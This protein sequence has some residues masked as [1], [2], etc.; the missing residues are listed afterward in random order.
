MLKTEHTEITKE[1][2]IIPLRTRATLEA[3]MITFD[4]T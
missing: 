3:R 2:S 4:G 1:K